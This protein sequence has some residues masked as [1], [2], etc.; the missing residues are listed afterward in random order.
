M[1]TS[2]NKPVSQK[3]NQ[4]CQSLHTYVL[5]L[6]GTTVFDLSHLSPPPPREEN[7]AKKQKTKKGVDTAKKTNTYRI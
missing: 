1:K 4:S 3:S 5:A 7:I 6:H 2:S